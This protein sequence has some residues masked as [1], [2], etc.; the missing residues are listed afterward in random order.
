MEVLLARNTLELDRTK[1]DRD[2]LKTA[3]DQKMVLEGKIADFGRL[4]LS[5]RLERDNFLVENDNAVHEAKILG[6][7]GSV[8]ATSSQGLQ[9]F[10]FSEIGAATCNFDPSLIIG[11]GGYGTVY[12]GFL[13]NTDVAIKLLDSTSV[14]GCSEFQQE[15]D[16]LSRM[17]HPNL[18][19]LIGTCPEARS[20]V[21]EYVPNGNLQ[22]R[23][24]CKDNTSPL[25]WKTRICIA[26]D[27]CS[28]LIFLHLNKPHGI[29]HGD[30]KPAN[31]LLDAN[32]ISKLGDFGISRSMTGDETST[33]SGIM[34]YR[35]NNPKGTPVYIDPDFLSTGELTPMSDVYSF[36]I[37]LLQL[38]TGRPPLGI[39]K[40]VQQG[41][42]SGIFGTMLDTSAGNWPF[43]QAKQIAC[44]ALRCCE[45]N[46]QN[47]PDLISQ[48]WKVLE[49][50]K[51][52]LLSP[53]IYSKSDWSDYTV[54]YNFVAALC[55]NLF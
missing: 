30:L 46:R 6:K 29:V 26:V 8:E 45:L 15:V 9:F 40:E 44:L 38:L 55:R 35:T 2:E 16:V 48:V 10:S 14:Q 11:D 34:C 43:V 12:K 24:S 17:R 7:R 49:P 41:L 13:R 39:A 28:A 33:S 53:T 1:K 19:T 50:M 27:I 31:V 47:R 21:Y 51:A 36:G 4:F 3:L 5:F 23:L 52:S 20:L 42:D 32:L 25:S 54:N 22:D 18:V 37:V